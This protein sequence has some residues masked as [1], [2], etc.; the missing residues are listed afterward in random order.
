M[1]ISICKW[2]NDADSPVLFMID[3]LANVWVD[4]TNNGK[5]ELGE[6]WGYWKNEDNSSFRFLN[7]DIL[8]FFP[9]VKVT[10]FVPV[11][12]RVGMIEN[13]KIPSVSNFIN[14]DEETKKFF[15]EV[16]QNPKF[17]LTY[18]GTTHGK[19]GITNND[20]KQEWELFESVE[21]AV[22]TIEYGNEI[23]KDTTGEYAKGGKYCGYASNQY[24]D[25]SIDKAGFSWWCRFWNK[26]LEEESN[27][28]IGGK[29]F[30]RLTNYDIKYFGKNKVVDIPSTVNGALMN[31][32]LKKEIESFKDLIKKALKG[33]LIKKR[34]KT[35][36]YL[37]DN[38]LVISIQE[39]M[40]P[41]RDDGRRQAPNIIDDKY[42]LL[43]LF[44]YLKTKNVWYCTGSELA[45]YVYLRDHIEIQVN[46]KKNSFIINCP[47]KRDI[48][49]NNLTL[50]INSINLEAILLPNGEK[51]EVRNNKVNIP[52]IQ[53]EYSLSFSTKRIGDY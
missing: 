12:I 42:S 26:G 24:S 31:D 22:A 16:H 37:L 13:P 14:C 39:H 36:D 4:T 52:I 17:E 11:G 15:R 43:H 44:N 27:C 23:F 45:D 5:L 18:H 3:D 1:N 28:A 49:M 7:E 9:N 10:F 25:D 53:G 2:F 35:V 38:K 30:N 51:I 34:M 50:R 47:F 46:E 20:F 29:D 33:S 40:A 21:G 41:S 32:L 6:D 8:S 19:V 48:K